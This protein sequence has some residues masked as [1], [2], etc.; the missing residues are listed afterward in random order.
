MA[1]SAPTVHPLVG[2]TW[3]H[4]PTA[5]QHGRGRTTYRQ[6]GGKEPNSKF[7]VR[8]LLNRYCLRTINKSKT[9]K[10]T[11]RSP[12]GLYRI[13]DQPFTVNFSF[14]CAKLSCNIS[15]KISISFI[16]R[17]QRPL[18]PELPRLE[19]LLLSVQL[20]FLFEL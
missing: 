19:C 18:N 16:F 17:D 20:S 9:L 6:P 8:F 12:D 7:Q 1:V 15:L 4:G 2:V 13:S 14:S 10:P 11:R 5:Q 3:R